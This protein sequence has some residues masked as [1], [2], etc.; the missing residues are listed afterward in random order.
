MDVA[1][2][3]A[4]AIA[5][6]TG[7]HGI[8]VAAGTRFLPPS[9]AAG[10]QV[11][12]V[13]DDASLRRETLEQSRRTGVSL[14]LLEGIVLSPA[15]DIRAFPEV[16][17]VVQELGIPQV[18]TF[19]ADP[20]RERARCCLAALCNQ[21]SAR[22][23]TVCVEF[24]PHSYLRSVE[25]AAALIETGHYPGLGIL[26]DALH[27]A[28]GGGTPAEVSR[29][30]PRLIACTQFCDGPATSPD[31]AAYRYEA[32]FER[33]IPGDG[34]FPL[35]ELLEAI[36]EEDRIVYLEIPMKSLRD[37]G[38]SPLDCA[39]RALEGMRRLERAASDERRAGT[40]RAELRS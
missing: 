3:E 21:A 6:E 16:L 33:Q 32:M 34:A 2:P 38:I 17:D 36:P 31:R 12:S 24:H 7:Y 18:A 10:F 37:R 23:I 29:I 26:V 8:S 28:R 20:D 13:V 30:D 25:E 11:H 9:M 15:L 40:G 4:L 39:Q 22:G 5:G 27:L 19:D 1:P 35:K 14:D